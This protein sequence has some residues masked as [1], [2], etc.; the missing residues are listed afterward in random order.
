MRLHSVD[1]V[2]L[3]EFPQHHS[4]R[5]FERSL[6]KHHRFF[7]FVKIPPI[8][9]GIFV[10]AQNVTNAVVHMEEVGM[11]ALPIA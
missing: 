5:C 7:N 4:E 8:Y 3:L 9:E 1:S 11:M 6:V 10:L 2:S